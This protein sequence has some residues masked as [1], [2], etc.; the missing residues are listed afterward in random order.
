[1]RGSCRHG[2]RNKIS[3]IT[4]ELMVKREEKRKAS[5]TR[6]RPQ[7]QYFQREKQTHYTPIA[8]TR[9]TQSHRNSL[10][11]S[12]F[13]S[14]KDLTADRV[15]KVRFSCEIRRLIKHLDPIILILQSLS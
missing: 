15:I 7:E 14:D 1:M 8:A 3:N 11:F 10:N 2:T 5:D 9:I 12:Q 6:A 4:E 13:L